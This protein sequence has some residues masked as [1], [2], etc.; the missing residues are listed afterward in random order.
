MSRNRR[1][2]KGSGAP[3][4]PP[5]ILL[6]LPDAASRLRVSGPTVRRLAQLNGLPARQHGGQWRVSASELERW[7][8]AHGWDNPAPVIKASELSKQAPQ[9]ESKNVNDIM[10]V[11]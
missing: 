6:S 8:G 5:T 9:P 2:S 7:C 11:S 4:V 1:R 3:A 10:G